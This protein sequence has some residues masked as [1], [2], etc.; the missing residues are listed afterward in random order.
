MSSK[1]LNC[2]RLASWSCV[3]GAVEAAEALCGHRGEDRID[4]MKSMQAGNCTSPYLVLVA[5]AVDVRVKVE[6]AEAVLELLPLAELVLLRV[7]VR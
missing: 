5:V 4:A 2:C 6:V 7:R 1:R 3:G